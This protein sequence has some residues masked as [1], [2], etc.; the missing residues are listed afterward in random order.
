MLFYLSEFVSEF[1]C[2]KQSMLNESS[3][4]AEIFRELAKEFD[5]GC[6]NHLVVF[7]FT[8]VFLVLFG[9]KTEEKSSPY[10][11]ISVSFL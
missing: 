8:F 9:T 7:R 10:S 4:F 5:Q 2:S 1:L 3:L 6:S 11:R